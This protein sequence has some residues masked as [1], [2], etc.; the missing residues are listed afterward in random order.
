MPRTLDVPVRIIPWR[1][2]NQPLNGDVS[3]SVRVLLSPLS[4][5]TIITDMCSVSK[6]TSAQTLEK[7]C[8]MT[9]LASYTLLR[10]DR[11]TRV[12]GRATVLPFPLLSELLRTFQVF[13]R[14]CSVHDQYLALMMSPKLGVGWRGAQQK[15]VMA[16]VR[17]ISCLWH[18]Y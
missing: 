11:D 1:G 8:F 10:T 17:N 18:T 16:K 9:T 12:Q 5:V 6:G 7:L 3:C 4:S 2:C 15:K 14:P 13:M